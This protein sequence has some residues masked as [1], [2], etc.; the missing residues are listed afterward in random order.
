ML[1]RLKI[2]VH[3]IE[4]GTPDILKGSPDHNLHI[5]IRIVGLDHLFVPL[6]P[7]CTE[8]PFWP[9]TPPPLYRTLVTP[10]H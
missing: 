10:D 8:H 4:F 3:D 9:F 1:L 6:F 2:S 5:L 7:W